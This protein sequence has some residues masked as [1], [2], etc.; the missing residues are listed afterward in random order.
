M[1]LENAAAYEDV[2]QST[3]QP[4]AFSDVWKY[5]AEIVTP[6]NNIDVNKVLRY[7]VIRAHGDDKS[8]Y[9]DMTLLIVRIGRRTYTNDIY[10]NRDRLSIKLRRTE[11]SPDGTDVPYGETHHKLFKATITDAK[12]LD[13]E[14]EK[15]D[16][17]DGDL[18]DLVDQIDIAFQLVEP[19]AYEISMSQT[20]NVF[21][22]VTVEDV[23]R[24]S[25]GYN[26]NGKQSIELLN[27][28]DYF[29]I[30]GVDVY[31]P[32]NK[33]RY[34]QIY[35][36]VGTRTVDVPLYLQER[37]GVY[38][39]GIGYYLQNG[40][41][42]VFPLRDYTLFG[43]RRKTLTVVNL[44]EAEAPGLEKSYFERGDKVFIVTTGE[45]ESTDRSQKAMLTDGNGIR[46]FRS[47]DLLDNMSVPS[48]NE[49]KTRR[50]ETLRSMAITERN[51]GLYNAEYV[52]GVFSDNPYNHLS[53]KTQA[54]GSN[55]MVNW[56][57][58]DPSLLYPGMPVRLMYMKKG[59]LVTQYGVLHGSNTVISAASEGL[60]DN[61]FLANTMLQLFLTPG[62]V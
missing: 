48:K 19:I 56:R 18:E 8:L 13:A 24:L 57:K 14:S 60:T 37:Y 4:A 38:S 27:R 29:G 9:C 6:D 3:R 12:D 16:N 45:V 44:S 54:M 50:S 26:L 41:W 39:S 2:I 43:K 10:P 36:P 20:G 34:E 52:P 22:D 25:L 7:N 28:D 53:P 5:H 31:S 62:T 61:V 51:D 55:I 47:S 33:K 11:L 30:R 49:L 17:T 58:S 15:R 21:R 59:E 40:R 32:T 46:F 42:Y 35:I 1:A 23:I